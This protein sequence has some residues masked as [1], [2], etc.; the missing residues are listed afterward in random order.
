[1]NY[2]LCQDNYAITMV[3]QLAILF[4]HGFDVLTTC[5]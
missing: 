2:Q 4:A 1:M 3:N 5:L